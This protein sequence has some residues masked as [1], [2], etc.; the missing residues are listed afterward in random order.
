MASR[1][2]KQRILFAL[3]AFRLLVAFIVVVWSPYEILSAHPGRPLAD[4]APLTLA[5]ALLIALGMIVYLWCAWDFAS[6]GLSFGPHSL[7]ARGIYGWLRHPMY[8]SLILVLFG[9]SL[10]FKSWRLLGY[11]SVFWLILHAFVVLFE[12]PRMAKRW[13]ASY[14]QYC[15]QVP[16]WIPKFRRLGV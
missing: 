4:L 5:G 13:G 14:P 2:S 1:H 12:E 6:I 8:F 11:A 15:E 10:F 3:L 9:E 16:R 7:V